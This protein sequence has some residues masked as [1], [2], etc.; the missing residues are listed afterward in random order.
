MTETGRAACA[1]VGVSWFDLSG[2]AHIVTPRLRVLIE[3][4]PNKFRQVGRPTS[5]FAPKS[6]R[7]VRWLL[8]NP[9]VAFTQLELALATGLTQ[10][11]VS[12]I[13]AQLEAQSYVTR[14]DE[15][16]A[17]VARRGKAPIR[18]RDP[19]LLLDAWA[20]EYRFDK[21][22]IFRGHIAA[23]SGD[24]LARQVSDALNELK[25]E[26]AATGLAAAWQMDHFASFRTATFY[27]AE[28]PSAGLME[29]LRFRADPRGSNTWIVVPNDAGIFHG[30][31]PR[32]G[33]RCVSAVQ[34]YL[35]LK[36]H[37]E[38][39]KEAAEHLRSNRALFGFE[40]AAS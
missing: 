16:S 40:N 30:A 4:K 29:L 36:H 33:I 5:V 10:G 12:Q 21:H 28:P 25:V 14:D 1:A 18:V 39:A 23:R 22:A 11:F 24:A 7:I 9:S 35:D 20:E 32:D 2:N 19:D 27:V 37:S 13:V 31:E 34:A 3:G 38:R 17:T 15:P 8:L 6:A 26:H